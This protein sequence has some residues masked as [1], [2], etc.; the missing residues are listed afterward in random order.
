MP[1]TEQGR[2]FGNAV[3]AGAPSIAD[4]WSEPM[5]GRYTE[6]G[7]LGTQP[8]TA[9]AYR[10]TPVPD[11]PPATEVAS[12]PQPPDEPQVAKPDAQ[13][14]EARERAVAAG[15][16]P[17]SNRY[18]VD[19]LTGRMYD[20]IT[21]DRIL[22]PTY[23]SRTIDG[24]AGVTPLGVV[25]SPLALVGGLT[26]YPMSLGQLMALGRPGAPTDAYGAGSPDKNGNYRSYGE[27]AEPFAR[28]SSGSGV[29]M[30]A[31]SGGGGGALS[32]A[33]AAN[34]PPA[35]G[36]DFLGVDEDPRTYG[37]RAMRRYYGTA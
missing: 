7:D 21:G 35:G 24:I 18:S 34:L 1:P 22:N 26:G 8:L 37:L 13:D 4:R 15:P 16:M 36:R 30:P 3:I 28:A 6:L 29:A 33:V 19:P 2:G 27:G 9:A 12:V 14:P 11:L 5:A 31:P 25:N 32:T 10:D 17:N 20:N 23:V